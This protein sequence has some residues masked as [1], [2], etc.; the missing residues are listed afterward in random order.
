MG[1]GNNCRDP[2]V[3]RACRGRREYSTSCAVFLRMHWSTPQTRM[4]KMTCETEVSLG[5]FV[6]AGGTVRKQNSKPLP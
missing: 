6:R 4:H 2:Q 1:G 5:L 3:E